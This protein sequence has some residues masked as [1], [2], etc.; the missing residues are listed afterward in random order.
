MS[1][2]LSNELLN[3]YRG[4]RE[5]AVAVDFADRIVL[6]N[7]ACE[8]L[9]GRPAQTALGKRCWDV[10][11][12]R[13]ANGNVYCHPSCP[14]AFQAREKPTDPVRPFILEVRT[15]DGRVKRVSTSLDVIPN[16]RPGSA[17]VIHVLAEAEASG[18]PAPPAPAR[19][20]AARSVGA[21]AAE[22]A[23]DLE[24]TDREREVLRAMAAGLPTASI[25]KKLG[26]ATVTVRNHVQSILQKLD[27][28][29]KVAAVALAYRHNL[30]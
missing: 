7:N 18:A 15:G 22:A 30:I 25:G 28:H 16:A 6:W 2:P 14:V 19:E 27:V 8:Q 3:R 5:A 17:T 20:V 11:C 10:L 9:L 26:I 1:I 4:S 21:A 12:G 29:N 23:I 13:D 24:L